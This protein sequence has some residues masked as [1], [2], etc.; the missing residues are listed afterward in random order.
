MKTGHQL[1]ELIRQLFCKPCFVLPPCGLREK[2]TNY[3]D[4]VELL[5]LFF[6]GYEAARISEYKKIIKSNKSDPT[7]GVGSEF[8][9]MPHTKRH[10][11]AEEDMRPV[12]SILFS[13]I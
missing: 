3:S 6:T 10:G 5:L 2:Y 1:N 4:H 9:G 13:A 11:P 8:F 7:T 12:N